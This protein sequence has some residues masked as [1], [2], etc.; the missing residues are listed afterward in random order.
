MGD[1]ISGELKPHSYSVTEHPSD[2][3]IV[4]EN[5]DDDK[6]CDKFKNQSNSITPY[7]EDNIF[8][9]NKNNVVIS[10][11]LETE[12]YSLKED[13][14]KSDDYIATDEPIEDNVISSIIETE[15]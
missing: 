2:C 4:N 5:K 15:S 8:E 10:D 12:S 7:H 6:A 9:G 1:V 13:Y 11:K 3:V 14:N